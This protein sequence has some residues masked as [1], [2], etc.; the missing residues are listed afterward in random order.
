[1]LFAV[2]RSPRLRAVVCRPERGPQPGS[3]V[4][5]FGSTFSAHR[6]ACSS[7]VTSWA[8]ARPGGGR[9]RPALG[10]GAVHGPSITAVTDLPTLRVLAALLHIDPATRPTPT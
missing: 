2:E 10:T 1:K 8:R 7:M 6:S 4:V 9:S 3:P 5:A